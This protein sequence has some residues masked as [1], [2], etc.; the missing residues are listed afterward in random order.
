MEIRHGLPGLRSVPPGAVLSV[1]NYDGIHL[2][3]RRLLDLANAEREKGGG[4]VAIVTFEP[5][6]LTVL[7]PE[8]APPR[9]TSPA[10]KQQLL[11]DAGVDDYVVLPPAPD[12]LNLTAEAFWMILRDEVKP[13][14]MIEGRSFNFGKG[15]GGN[16]E[17]LSEWSKES[18]I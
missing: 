1:G 16:I 13:R 2:G 14:V 4:R 12:V 10:I 17:R 9:L 3:H 5:H 15:R 6:P 7:R 18:P 11:A 8:F